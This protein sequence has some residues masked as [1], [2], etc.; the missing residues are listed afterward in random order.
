VVRTLE[1]KKIILESIGEAF[2]AVDKQ[3][4]VTYWNRI[5]EI[6]LGVKKIDI[7]NKNLWKIFSDSI[8]SV[9]FVKYHEALATSQVVHFEDYYAA[10]SKWYE[11]SAYPSENGLSVF[12]KD[13]TE[14]KRAADEIKTL[15]EG[16]E[17][18]V[19]ER[20]EE[21]MIVN[22][23]L[24]SFSYSV[25]HDL[26]APLRAINGNATILEEDYL[27]KLD[28]DGVKVIHSIL[29]S[30]KKMGVLID[31]LLAFSKLGR[32]QVTLSS[33][34]MKELVQSILEELLD[35]NIR[36]RTT[37]NLKPLPPVQGDYSL[38][39]QVWI[40]LFSNAIKYSGNKAKVEIEIGAFEKNNMVV[41]YVKDNGVGFDMQ[42]YNKLFGVFQR[43]HSHEEFEGTGI[44]LA[45]VQKIV[46]RHHGA[47]WAE[48][49]PNEGACFYFS[50]PANI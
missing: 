25:S 33:I 32:K 49:K 31:D 16:L 36:H 1:D 48:S 23:E 2:F 8:D 13:I 47:V 43:L 42:Y 21:L 15:N 35:E 38:I 46:T 27:E 44:G 14:R 34:N 30:S 45:N 40:N 28:E 17:K 29:R 3:W 12:F 18:R 20:T 19:H 24:E 7:I 39:K 50:L 37:V 26:R 22:K 6:D 4:K 10:L 11:I 5:A 9:S 41:Y